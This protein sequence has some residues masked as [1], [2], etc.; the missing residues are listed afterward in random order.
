MKVI[1]IKQSWANLI[2]HGIKDIG[3]Q[4]WKCLKNYTI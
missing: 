2:V 1:F 4:T 3:N